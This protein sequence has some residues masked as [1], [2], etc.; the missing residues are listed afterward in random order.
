M[1]GGQLKNPDPMT[2][3]M[4]QEDLDVADIPIR[5]MRDFPL[6]MML[7]ID[8][9]RA[10]CVEYVSEKGKFVDD[11]DGRVFVRV[12]SGSTARDAAEAWHRIRKEFHARNPGVAARLDGITGNSIVIVRSE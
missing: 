3:A 8:K 2:K 9:G 7:F 1:M 12:G 5:A 10:D 6:D 11:L 4:K